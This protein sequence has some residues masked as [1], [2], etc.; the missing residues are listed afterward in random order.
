MIE[1]IAAQLFGQLIA[2]L[3]FIKSV[4]DGNAEVNS[5]YFK[6]HITPV[7]DNFMRVHANYK[8]TF[9]AY[10]EMT[11]KDDFQIDHLRERVEGDDLFSSD[12]RSDLRN[13]AHAISTNFTEEIKDQKT[14][15]LLK[16]VNSIEEYLDYQ[17]FVPDVL[18]SSQSNSITNQA[19]GMIQGLFMMTNTVA[20]G[21]L[22]TTLDKLMLDASRN[23]SNR[24]VKQ[25]VR[26]TFKEIQK[27]Y[28]LVSKT[29]QELRKEFP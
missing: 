18:N 8:E 15:L 29:Y 22:L 28:D 16:F 1:A 20:R 14:R 9:K 13:S 4:R 26:D 3:S 11:L 7:W 21:S 23:L 12:W 19:A 25:A 27:R 6:E 24:A 10:E 17:S 5:K 2:M